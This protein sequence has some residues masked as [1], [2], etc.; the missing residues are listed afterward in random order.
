MTAPDPDKLPDYYARLHVAPD[1]SAAEI[2]AA[3]RELVEFCH[4]YL[5]ALNPNIRWAANLLMK[6][7]TEAYEV[8]RDGARRHA[9]D[10]RRLARLS[11]WNTLTLQPRVVEADAADD[12]D[13]PDV[14]QKISTAG[15]RWPGWT[16]RRSTMQANDDK[17]QSMGVFNK[18]ML[19]PVPFFLATIVAALF[20]HLGQVT[21]YMPL[22]VISALL[23]YVCI[24][25]PLSLRLLFPIRHRPLLS[26]RQKLA[27]TPLLVF[28]VVLLGWLWAMIF[29]Q[30]GPA[31]NQLDL[32]FW[33]GL[34]MALCISLAYL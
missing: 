22:G 17:K 24:V 19:L 15:P 29:D 10:K 3:F 1:A 28:T 16:W 20:W 33:C 32:Y 31:P 21:G 14:P 12:F 9:Y 18:A 25:I 27:V 30:H 13:Q 6:E 34:L 5:H 7:I 23:A 2:R 11:D 8:L 4:P 26:L